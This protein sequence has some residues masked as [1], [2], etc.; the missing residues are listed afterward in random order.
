MSRVAITG[1]GL[2]TSIGIQRDEF[3]Q[4]LFLGKCGI[5]QIQGDQ[6]LD[7]TTLRSRTAYR[8]TAPI[9]ELLPTKK[10]YLDRC[11]ALT[12]A[13]CWLALRDGGIE[14]TDEESPNFGICHGTAYGCEDSMLIFW[15]RILKR[16]FRG[17]SSI[18]FTHAYMN[19]PISLAAIEFNL[20]GYHCCYSAGMVSGTQAIAGG[21]MA[22]KRSLAK[23]I[24]AG[25]SEAFSAL[26]FMANYLAG[27]LSPNDDGEEMMRPFDVSC[28]GWVM[29]EG[30]CMVL[31][32]DEEAAKQRGAKVLGYIDGVGAAQPPNA[33]SAN[34]L[35][36]AIVRSMVGAL[37]AAGIEPKQVGWICASANGSK[38]IDEAEAIAIRQVFGNAIPV[39]SQKAAFGETVGA[40]GPISVCVALA[41]FARHEIPPTL[42]T[43]KPRADIQLIMNQ[44]ATWDADK[45]VL[46]NSVDKGGAAMSILIAPPR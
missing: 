4:N 13:S 16:G 5:S 34:S 25:G 35:S 39:S 1:V 6:G 8:V 15:E 42:F 44:P 31:L 33:N 19:T 2:I 22:I 29:G 3:A 20:K 11:S 12:I 17:A 28:N 18:M 14:V 38:R 40:G 30:A 21:A 37:Q 26:Q 9:D 24:L 41:S 32:E 46:V 43:T 45:P 7:M 23:R 27:E 10:A 36:D